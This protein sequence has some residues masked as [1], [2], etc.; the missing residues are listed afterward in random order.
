MDSHVRWEFPPI[1]QYALLL[2]VSGRIS[3]KLTSIFPTS[4]EVFPANYILSVEEIPAIICKFLNLPVK[5]IV[6]VPM[7]SLLEQTDSTVTFIDV[8]LLLL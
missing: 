5:A 1:Y 2:L 8:V 4:K 3:P 6:R 7:H